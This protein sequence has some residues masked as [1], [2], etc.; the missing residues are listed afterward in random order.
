MNKTISRTEYFEAAHLLPGHNGHCKNLH[1]H[2]YL[3]KATVES[4]APQE[5]GMVMD[6]AYLKEAMKAVMPDHKYL[7]F[8]GN[9][10][11]E[12]IVKILD[13]YNLEYVTYPFATS[14]ENMAPVIMK[15]LQDYITNTL[16][17]PNVKV[18]EVEIHET[19]N[20]TCNVKEF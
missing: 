7:H 13:E 1:G 6:Y 9:E 4:D 2:S 11:S 12:K 17:M 18:V 16:K 5:Y 10:I 3:F 14:V 15:Q 8:E 19:Q 20:S